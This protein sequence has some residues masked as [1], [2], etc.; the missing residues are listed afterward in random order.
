MIMGVA[1][2][3]VRPQGWK[4]WLC[5]A[6]IAGAALAGSPAGA[7]PT[8]PSAPT[9][10]GATAGLGSVTVTYSAPANDG[11]APVTDYRVAC[12]S[13]DG[14]ASKS[15]TEHASPT[16]VR[17]LTAGKTYT[18]NVMARN[19][20]GYGPPSALSAPVV[21]L[22]PP[23]APTVPGAPTITSAVAGVKSV[24]VTYSPPAS[25]GG[26]KIFQ[27]KVACT[28]SDGGA[29]R[30]TTEHASPTTL[31]NLTAAKT[32]TCNVEAGNRKGFGPPS[33]LSVPVVTLSPPVITVPGAPT[34][35]SVTA[36][37]RSVTVAFTPPAA[38]GGASIFSY[39]ATCTSSNGGVTRSNSRS[40]SSIRVS[41]L[42]SGKTYTCTVAARNRKGFGAASAPSAAVTTKTH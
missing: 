20:A 2:S 35:T 4:A 36:G 28:S 22:S 19:K 29:S 7:A 5:G 31:R 9:I 13:S 14:G 26:S 11:G 10:T 17:N 37:F 12:T 32:Y 6:A 38:N 18:C 3:L 16:T 21:T 34:I 23:P 15:T 30:S 8:V 27:Y 41:G 1:T 40:R 33:A 24:K 39:R 42:S 25:D